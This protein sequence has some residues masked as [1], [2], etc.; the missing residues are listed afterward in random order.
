METESPDPGVS[1]TATPSSLRPQLHT[2]GVAVLAFALGGLTVAAAPLAMSWMDP[3]PVISSMV[4]I[5]P[6]RSLLAAKPGFEDARREQARELKI[7]QAVIR[8]D[9]VLKMALGSPR[10]GKIEVLKRQ[11]DPVN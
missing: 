11:S 6:N 2:A 8:S 1:S 4:Q 7:Q 5:E 3:E 10:L 9:K